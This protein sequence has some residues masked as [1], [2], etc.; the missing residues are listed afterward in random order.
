M[1]PVRDGEGTSASASAATDVK[2]RAARGREWRKRRRWMGISRAFAAT[3]LDVAVDT[4]RRW[5]AGEIP[6]PDDADE[7]LDGIWPVLS[8]MDDKL[9]KDLRNK[10]ADLRKVAIGPE[11]PDELRGTQFV[12]ARFLKTQDLRRFY[13]QIK[14]VSPNIFNAHVTRVKERLMAMGAEVEL[15]DFN[16]RA[17]DVYRSIMRAPE[18]HD[19]LVMWMRETVGFV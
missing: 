2:D 15:I 3:H 18:N 4:V 19:T 9:V 13:P 1:D 10:M 17:Y 5:E 12:F 8:A 14:A 7:M 6:L 11:K 16:R